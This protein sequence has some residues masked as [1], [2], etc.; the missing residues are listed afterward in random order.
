[1]AVSLLPDKLKSITA[2]LVIGITFLI[3]S[4]AFSQNTPA[5]AVNPSSGLQ[6]VV[7]FLKADDYGSAEH[8]LNELMALYPD[9]AYYSIFAFLL[10]KTHYKQGYLDKSEKELQS[11]LEEFPNSIYIGDTLLL[12]GDIRFGQGDP[13][14]AAYY[15]I[16]AYDRIN[17]KSLKEKARQSLLNIVDAHISLSRLDDLGNRA[18]NYKLSPEMLY[19]KAN[20]EFREGRRRKAEETIALLQSKFPTSPFSFKATQLLGKISSQNKGMV[21][22]GVIAPLSGSMASYGIEML[23]GVKLA[24]Q[25]SKSKNNLNVSVKLEIFDN[26]GT[27]GKT[28][29]GVEELI[30]RD[31]SLIIGPLKSANAFCAAAVCKYH[32]DIPLLVPAASAKGIASVADNVFQLTPDSDLISRKIADYA[33]DNLGINQFAILSPSDDYGEE[34]SAAFAREIESRGTKLVKISFYQRGITDFKRPLTEIKNVLTAGMDTL[35]AQ[36]LVDSSLYINPKK[37]DELLPK[38][39]WPVELGAMFIPG[40][41]DE[42]ALIAPQVAFGQ[43]KTVL[44]GNEGWADPDVLRTARGYLDGSVFA[45]D[46]FPFEDDPNWFSFSQRF[47]KDFSVEP[48]RVAGLSYDAM[49][50]AL[51]SISKSK[52]ANKSLYIS[53]IEN[54]RGVTGSIS[55][56]GN[57]GLNSEVILCKITDGKVYRIS[58]K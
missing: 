6:Q 26:S 7:G 44:L 50:L 45:T 19:H 21:K 4:S 22:I 51:K 25:D 43:I 18:L 38:F 34:V 29:S 52:S 31:V 27:N 3:S 57:N 2:V 12:L 41:A 23:R 15:Y 54:Y 37:P 32:R 13:F 5:P 58:E 8:L 28:I 17:N 35:L 49:I 36:G 30:A 10:A 39:E 1:V 40:Y 24:L 42:V 11:F 53:E 48:S 14:G 56:K 9:D 16:Q 33:V 46:F 55:F 47:K 20:R